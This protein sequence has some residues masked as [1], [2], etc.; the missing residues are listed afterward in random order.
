MFEA[1]YPLFLSFD[2]QKILTSTSA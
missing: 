2:N 1:P